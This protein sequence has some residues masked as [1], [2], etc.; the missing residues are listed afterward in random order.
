MNLVLAK[1]LKNLTAKLSNGNL[2][3]VR[4]GNPDVLNAIPNFATVTLAIPADGFEANK[5]G[6][7][8]V[9]TLAVKDV[10]AS[11][12]ENPKQVSVKWSDSGEVTDPVVLSTLAEKDKTEELATFVT[13]QVSKFHGVLS[14]SEDGMPV[15]K[16]TDNFAVLDWFLSD[17]A[18][19][20]QLWLMFMTRSFINDDLSLWNQRITDAIT[21]SGIYKNLPV[22]PM[23]GY[24]SW[25][26]TSDSWLIK[27]A[28]KDSKLWKGTTS[29]PGGIEPRTSDSFFRTRQ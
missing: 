16:T 11:S 18:S 2:L 9:A 3:D 13:S 21:K 10:L 7:D 26:T 6:L 22:T 15:G 20:G 23:T 19:Q 14:P 29:V 17:D 12:L 28:L 4:G 1:L 27:L 24:P 8:D 25:A 5:A